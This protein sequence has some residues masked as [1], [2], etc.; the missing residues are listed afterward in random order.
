MRIFKK[1]VEFVC[2]FHHVKGD[3]KCHYVLPLTY[4]Q[5][6]D[7][8]IYFFGLTVLPQFK[9]QKAIARELNLFYSV[10]HFLPLKVHWPQ[11]FPKRASHFLGMPSRGARVEPPRKISRARSSASEK[12][13]GSAIKG[14]WQVPMRDTPLICNWKWRK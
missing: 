7:I 8:K 6:V 3:H 9:I 4:F 11:R 10:S 5:V 13:S 2:I 12:G 1:I 14:C